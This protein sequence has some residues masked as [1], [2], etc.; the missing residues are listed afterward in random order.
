MLASLMPWSSRASE[1]DA[2]Y[3]TAGWPQF[4][5]PDGQGHAF[6]PIPTTWSDG[7]NNAWSVKIPG[8]GWSSPVVLDGQVW[9]TTAVIGAAG[10]VSLRAIAVHEDSGKIIHDVEVFSV[11]RPKPKTLHERNTFASPTPVLEKGKVYVHFGCYGTACIDT[12][13][14]QPLWKNDKLLVNH[15]TGP[16]SSPLLYRDRLI[17]TYDGSDEQYV[18]A[19]DT[20]SGDV[21]WKTERPEAKDRTPA[22]SRRAFCT[23]LLVNVAGKDQIVIPGAF[24]VYSYD[25]LNG[26]EVW[27]VKYG[28]FSN[29]P[30]PVF[31][32]GL[33]IVSSGFSPPDLVAIRPDGSGDVTKTHVVWKQRKNVPNVSSPI[34][35]VPTST[36]WPTR[37]SPAAWKPKPAKSSGP[38]V[39]AV[40][41]APRSWLRTTRSMP[42]RIAARRFCSPRQP[43]PTRNSAATN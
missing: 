22:D 19:L 20:A 41:I 4:R 2:Q 14:G 40:I 21:L 5:G 24:C 8:K 15:E 35:V 18:A 7:A 12:R 32:D 1:P 36:W 11:P 9:L 37:A 17:C 30:R 10:D 29:V 38:S 31:A 25:P 13:T 33:V 3:K 28:G 43:M 27:R 23:P 16:G 39:S 34:V 26:Q 6:G 42:L